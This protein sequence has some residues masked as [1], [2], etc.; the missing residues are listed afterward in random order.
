LTQARVIAG[1]HVSL[2][3]TGLAWAALI[4]GEVGGWFPLKIAFLAAA[5]TAAIVAL[6]ATLL[7]RSRLALVAL[8]LALP[9]PAT[10]VW[11]IRN[12]E[13]GEL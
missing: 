8:I 10:A 6:L 3:A 13:I 9:G 11:W 7:E 2:A 1:A 4:A 12:L 5:F